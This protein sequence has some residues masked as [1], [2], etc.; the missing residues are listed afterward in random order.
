MNSND[1]KNYV[2]TWCLLAWLGASEVFVVLLCLNELISFQDNFTTAWELFINLSYF[3]N[4]LL[5]YFKQGFAFFMVPH[6][7]GVEKRRS[8][9]KNF[10]KFNSLTFEW[11]KKKRNTR[12][13]L[14]KTS[15]KWDFLSHC[16]ME[17]GKTLFSLSHSLCLPWG[18]LLWWYIKNCYRNCL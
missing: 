3:F 16:W 11:K 18:F 15:L 9:L 7:S 14:M 6:F 12:E 10:N 13:K 2:W 5:C 17:D 8:V 4:V 1:D